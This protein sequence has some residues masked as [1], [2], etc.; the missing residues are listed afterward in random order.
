MTNPYAIVDTF[1]KTIAEFAGS[2]YAVAVESCTSA[3]FLSLQ[4]HKYMDQYFSKLYKGKYGVFDSISVPKKTY[5]GV[6]CSIIHSGWKVKFIDKKWQGEYELSPAN[7]WDAALRFKKGMYRRGFQ[8]LSFHIKKNLPIGRGGM[9]LTND[10]QAYEWFKKARF[11]GRQPVPLIED[12]FTMLGWNMYMQPA[13]A[14]RGLQLFQAMGNKELPDISVE[15]Q[16]YPDLSQFK[17][18]TQ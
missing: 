15:S 13:D 2:K 5:P 7:I 4:Y 10:K 3:I 8:C 11:D 6:P 1:E 18:Y 16:G 9:I 12:N 14:A 17:I